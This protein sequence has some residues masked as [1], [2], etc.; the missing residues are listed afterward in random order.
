MLGQKGTRETELIGAPVAVAAAVVVIRL[1][2]VVAKACVEGR[3][4]VIV[5]A[6]AGI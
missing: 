5:A 6:A 2:F 1:A 4:D 3:E